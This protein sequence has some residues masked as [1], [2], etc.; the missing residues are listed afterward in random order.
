MKLFSLRIFLIGWI[1]LLPTI[2]ASS[3][4]EAKAY[5]LA[6]SKHKAFFNEKNIEFFSHEIEFRKDLK[7]DTDSTTSVAGQLVH[8]P[9]AEGISR[10]Q[11]LNANHSNSLIVENKREIQKLEDSQLN[12][13]AMD[14]SLIA[15]S[16]GRKLLELSEPKN[17]L[18]SELTSPGDE[19][20]INETALNLIDRNTAVFKNHVQDNQLVK[21]RLTPSSENQ[22]PNS[23]SFQTD[24]AQ[25]SL[26]ERKS[27]GSV[28]EN[29]NPSSNPRDSKRLIKNDEELVATTELSKSEDKL[30][31]SPPSAQSNRKLPDQSLSCT[32]L[33]HLVESSESNS[34]IGTAKDSSFELR[35][36]ASYNYP[37]QSFQLVESIDQ[38]KSI[39]KE[40]LDCNNKDL[41]IRTQL[42]PKVTIGALCEKSLAKFM[43]TMLK[44]NQWCRRTIYRHILSNFNIRVLLSLDANLK[45]PEPIAQSKQE[46]GF[47]YATGFLRSHYQQFRFRYYRHH[48]QN[49]VEKLTQF[50]DTDLSQDLPFIQHQIENSSGHFTQ[51]FLLNFTQ[52]VE[53]FKTVNEILDHRRSQ[54]P[55]TTAVQK[56]PI[57]DGPNDKQ[58]PE[59]NPNKLLSWS[60]FVQQISNPHPI[61]QYAELAKEESKIPHTKIQQLKDLNMDQ[62]LL[63]SSIFAKNPVVEKQSNDSPWK[64]TPE[65]SQN[66]KEPTE[67]FAPSNEMSKETNSSGSSLLSANSAE[68]NP[69][70]TSNNLGLLKELREGVKQISDLKSQIDFLKTALNDVKTKLDEPAQNVGSGKLNSNKT[71]EKK[72]STSESHESAELDEADLRALGELKMISLPLSTGSTGTFAVVQAKADKNIAY[73]IKLFHKKSNGRYDQIHPYVITEAQLEAIKTIGEGK[74]SDKNDQESIPSSIIDLLKKFSAT[75]PHK[76]LNLSTQLSPAHA[77]PKTKINYQPIAEKTE[78]RK[79]TN[80]L[81]S[82]DS[83]S[84]KTEAEELSNSSKNTS[85]ESEKSPV[86]WIDLNKH[87]QQKNPSNKFIL[88]Q[89]P[90]SFEPLKGLLNDIIGTVLS[91]DDIMP[92]SNTVSKVKNL[93]PVSPSQL[94]AQNHLKQPAS[95]NHSNLGPSNS[96][97]NQLNDN[98]DRNKIVSPIEDPTSG[99][100][101]NEPKR[102]TIDDSK[103]DVQDQGQS[104]KPNLSIQGEVDYKL[105]ADKSVTK[106]FQ[107]PTDSIDVTVE[108]GDSKSSERPNQLRRSLGQIN[109]KRSLISNDR[110]TSN[111]NAISSELTHYSDD[112]QT[113]DF[114][115]KEQPD[116]SRASLQFTDLMA[117][118]SKSMTINNN[119]QMKI[120]L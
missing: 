103:I 22:S 1:C 8:L 47:D 93:G 72:I 109:L 14:S 10:S 31:V 86:N 34:F 62:K 111:G 110:I 98:K 112:S 50:F 61:T 35:S 58:P 56:E 45:L 94:L 113:D 67:H 120:V 119:N 51:A 26:N 107:I 65:S 24:A 6:E 101:L 85:F 108:D 15:K 92:P 44:L 38:L 57:K 2:S 5:K 42:A 87:D 33:T 96:F 100:V 39:A 52:E 80:N 77:T 16:A 41:E 73:P 102:E 49:L 84:D 32:S 88:A 29:T 106:S 79:D 48:Y 90:S 75:G 114:A 9:A 95:Q 54:K 76:I 81:D 97:S 63:K 64:S 7:S 66:F 68:N 104:V 118:N 20:I 18:L 83:D 78:N 30:K 19:M 21:T 12:S 70:E 60:E 28:F 11:F 3:I 91:E 82:D 89:S 59:K 36:S 25:M 74:A 55:S 117:H 27:K 17:I 23:S 43:Q 71:P 4:S 115:V 116:K 99:G 37:L 13:E 53:F 105:P 46:L 69:N 40:L